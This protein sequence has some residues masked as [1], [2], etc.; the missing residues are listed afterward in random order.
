[1]GWQDDAADQA[2]HDLTRDAERCGRV[3]RRHGG[4]VAPR[5]F[6]RRET[7]RSAVGHDPAAG[8]RLPVSGALAELVEGGC[9]GGITVDPRE[10]P[11]ERV[12]G[13]RSPPTMFSAGLWRRFVVITI[14]FTL[15]PRLTVLGARIE[16]PDERHGGGVPRALTNPWG[17]SR[18]A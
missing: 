11:D 9:D 4:A 10:S 2:A 13:G 14:P 1:M 3:A 18:R 12:V 16:R 7:D 6:V 8:P 17:S 15:F 5:W